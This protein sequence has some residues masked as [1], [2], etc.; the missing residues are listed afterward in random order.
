MW[1]NSRPPTTPFLL[2]VTLVRTGH[3][4]ERHSFSML[5]SDSGLGMSCA[6]TESS[7]FHSFLG[8]ETEAQERKGP[9]N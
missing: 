9:L 5:E 3:L 2:T 4:T 8:G 1:E 7:F 6:E